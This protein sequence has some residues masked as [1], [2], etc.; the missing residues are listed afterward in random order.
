[1]Q[2][3]QPSDNAIHHVSNYVDHRLAGAN[4]HDSAVQAGYSESTARTPSLI[5]HTKAYS[6]VVNDILGKNAALMRKMTDSIGHNVANGDFDSV[7]IAEQV[8][9]AYKMAKIYDI[10]TP[11]ITVQETTDKDGNKTRKA[12]GTAG[13]TFNETPSNEGNPAPWGNA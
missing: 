9:I 2:N 3:G 7:E 13:A 12:W 5:E 8:D 6:I 1:M 4:K 10:L 11:K